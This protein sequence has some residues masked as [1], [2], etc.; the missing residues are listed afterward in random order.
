M[1]RAP[2]NETPEILFEDTHLIV[3]SKPAGLLSQGEESG[4]PNLIDW[5][6]AHVGRN[7][8]GLVHRLDR[9]TSGAMV[10]AKRTK[11]AQRLTEALQAGKLTREY[12]AW[13]EGKLEPYGQARTWAHFLLKNEQTNR[14]TVLK[15]EGQGAKKAVL[16]T[17]PLQG[18]LFQGG[19]ITLMRLKLET[20]RSHQIRAQSAYEGLPILGD[21]KYGSKLDF[22]RMALHS[23]LIAFPHPMSGEE[24][25][26]EAALPEDMRRL[27][28]APLGRII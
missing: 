12:L 21:R 11:S 18:A 25:R 5:A 16:T 19:P 28:T 14:V 27:L 1:T 10:L 6:R 22:P 13:A 7:Y 2:A 26:F 20:G 3:I 24:L 15:R 4:E 9:G 8:V 23:W 17:T